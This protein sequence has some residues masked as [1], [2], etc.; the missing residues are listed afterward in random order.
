MNTQRVVTI[1][2]VTCV[3]CLV[4]AHTVLAQS[5]GPFSL[6]R[7]SVDGGGGSSSGG[8]FVARGSAGQADAGSV[9]GGTFKIS[10]GFWHSR[11]PDVVYLPVILR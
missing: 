2:I 9:Q 1:L 8:T 5:G 7:A 10:G 6:G 3:L 11:N 4:V